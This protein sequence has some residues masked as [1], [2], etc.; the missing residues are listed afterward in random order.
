MLAVYMAAAALLL[1]LP[2]AAP[3]RV[4]GLDSTFGAGGR[5]ATQFPP[6]GG[7]QVAVRS[8]GSV[9]LASGAVLNLFDP[10]GALD[11][12]FGVGGQLVLPDELEGL[13]FSQMHYAFDSRGRIVIFGSLNN[14]NWVYVDQS[15]LRSFNASWAVVMR[16]SPDGALDLSFGEGKGFVRSDFGVRTTVYPREAGASTDPGVPTTTPGAGVVDSQDRPVLVAESLAP[17][18]GRCFYGKGFMW[19]NPKAVVRLTLD[20]ALDWSF[21]GGDGV[22]LI[23]GGER[24]ASLQLDG[25]DGLV[26]ATNKMSCEQRDNVFRFG[27]D[28]LP[29]VGFGPVGVRVYRGLSFGAI[30]PAEKLT[31]GGG[32]VRVGKR[33]R[34]AILRTLASGNLDSSFGKGGKAAV[35]LPVGA[36]LS[37]AIAGVDPLGRTVLTGAFNLPK[38]RSKKPKGKPSRSDGKR[39]LLRSYVFVKRLLPNG[40][41]DRTLGRQGTITTRFERPRRLRVNDADLDSQGRLVLLIGSADARQLPGARLTIVRYTLGPL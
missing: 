2:A 19:P 34:P 30:G 38:P 4:G 24:G 31:L 9:L 35:R 29:K 1:C 13:P 37:W 28:G 26:V 18:D 14:P 8:D 33:I 16:L 21:G 41:L 22:A 40:K 20:G 17:V 12:A 25:A 36:D 32:S 23:S 10:N 15:A 27:A 39:K 7:L 6:D 11:P 3:A 5:V